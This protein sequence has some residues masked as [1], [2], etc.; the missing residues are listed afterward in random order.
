MV[1]ALKAVLKIWDHIGLLSLLLQACEHPAFGIGGWLAV[2][3][4][5]QG[6]IWLFLIHNCF[7]FEI[8]LYA[9]EYQM[10]FEDFMSFPDYFGAYL[11]SFA[12]YL[13]VLATSSLTK[14]LK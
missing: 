6:S 10:A 8:Q 12:P 14:L 2:F 3:G 1:M 5:A 7:M 11:V 9:N 13:P 4:W